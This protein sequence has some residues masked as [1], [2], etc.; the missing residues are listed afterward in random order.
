MKSKSLSRLANAILG[1]AIV[2]AC[3]LEYYLLFE[4][5]TGPSTLRGMLAQTLIITGAVGLLL[6]VCS[7]S[8]LKIKIAL[9]VASAGLPTLIMELVL[10]GLS[11]NRDIQT[12]RQGRARQ[13]GQTF[14]TRSKHEVITA[15]RTQGIAA[16]PSV[17]SYTFY[18]GNEALR[19]EDSSLIPLGGVSN[20]P[21]VCCNE[22]G[23]WLIYESDEHGF[24]NPKGLYH[25]GKVDIVTIG[26]SFAEGFCVGSNENSTA[27]L[28]IKYGKVLNLG[29]NGNGPL[30]NLATIVEYVEPL[31][32]R[33]VLWFH[34]EGNDLE[35]LDAE[36]K[37]P[38]V[39]Y[40]DA[41]HTQHLWSLQTQIDDALRIM[42]EKRFDQ[43]SSQKPP[44]S[45]LTNVLLL[46]RTRDK[47][48]SL[49]LA[50][51]KDRRDLDLFKD[52]LR[53]AHERTKSFGA[54]L[55]FVYLPEYSRYANARGHVDSYERVKELVKG[56]DIEFVD[57]CAA[58]LDS[59]DPLALFPFRAE[60]HYNSQGHRVIAE[61]VIRTL[62]VLGRAP[63]TNRE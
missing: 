48:S 31:K 41:G 34:Y 3:W 32:P 43:L 62:Q 55:L 27:L 59:G 12:I 15:L 56:L 10:Q 54:R 36:K 2:Y 7:K 5:R 46:R 60:G 13:E 22:C 38:L 40:L 35:D 51:A 6:L 33:L 11:D 25:P 17:H 52:T 39:K 4:P 26:D 1:L 30:S 37:S 21:T 23:Q 61:A 58:F 9:L 8:M 16:F 53:L 63:E 24:H 18:Y 20:A 50:G 44:P 28:R 49:R 42:I 47:L 19:V 45:F 57:G 29:A 14:D